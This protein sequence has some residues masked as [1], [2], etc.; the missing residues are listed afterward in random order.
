M[1]LLNDLYDTCDTLSAELSKVNNKLKAG[2]G[3]ITTQDLDYI[4]KL[5]HSIKS[6][7]TTKAMLEAKENGGHWDKYSNSDHLSHGN[8]N[9]Y[10]PNEQNS[11]RGDDMMYRLEQIARNTSDPTVRR[12]IEQLM[13]TNRR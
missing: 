3:T 11:Y 10:V 5:T 2:N 13:Y 9:G 6:V 12:D 8:Q 1:N 7:E 4:D